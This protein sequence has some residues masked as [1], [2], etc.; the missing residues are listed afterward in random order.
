MSIDSRRPPTGP[1][2]ST[3]TT[4][5]PPRSTA[6]AAA[7]PARPAPTIATSA[8]SAGTSVDLRPKAIGAHP[9]ST[10]MV[11]EVGGLR[12]ERL[13]CGAEVAALE[14]ADH[15]EERGR[16]PLAAGEV[17]PGGDRDLVRHLGVREQQRVRG[18]LVV[19]ATQLRHEPGVDRRGVLD[20]DPAVLQRV[21]DVGQRRRL[22]VDAVGLR[23]RI[24]VARSGWVGVVLDLAGDVRATLDRRILEDAFRS[25]GGLLQ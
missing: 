5:P 18:L 2:A 1:R 22:R 25:Q 4:D 16:G 24:V 10:G 17:S 8:S 7:I 3:R 20:L 11:L 6:R 23:D 9:T 12:L 15:V 21:D 13:G 14:V 19:E